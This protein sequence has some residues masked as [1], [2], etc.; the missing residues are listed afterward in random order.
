MAT[1]YLKF[2]MGHVHNSIERLT[3]GN[4]VLS[5]ITG[6][7]NTSTVGIEV[8]VFASMYGHL[9][10]PTVGSMITSEVFVPMSVII[11]SSGSIGLSRDCQNTF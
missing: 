7:I 10:T 4:M 6:G 1:L 3:C 11:L 2:L 9:K 5:P 8:W